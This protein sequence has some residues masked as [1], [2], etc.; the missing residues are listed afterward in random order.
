LVSEWGIYYDPNPTE[1]II[2]EDQ[3]LIELWHETE[4]LQQ[5]D[6]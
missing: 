4:E 3:D 2:S 6:D 5:N 1:T